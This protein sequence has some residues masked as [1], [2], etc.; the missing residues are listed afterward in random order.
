MAF[1]NDWSNISECN[2]TFSVADVGYRAQVIIALAFFEFLSAFLCASFLVV[3]TIRVK[4][5]LWDTAAKRFS[6]ALT[7]CSILCFLNEGALLIVYLDLT[8]QLSNKWYIWYHVMRIYLY[9]AY[10]LY[11]TAS[12]VWLLLQTGGPV[13]PTRL[14]NLLSSR[15]LVIMEAVIQ[16]S[17]PLLSLTNDIPL[18][19]DYG[20]YSHQVQ[21]DKG[22]GLLPTLSFLILCILLSCCVLI[23]CFT[24]LILGFFLIRFL[25]STFTTRRI[26]ILILKLNFLCITT[27]SLIAHDFVLYTS[28][29]SPFQ[30]PYMLGLNVVFILFF[31]VSLMLLNYP[32]DTWCLNCFKKSPSRSPLLPINN[33]E[34]EQTN[35]KSVWDHRCVPSHTTTN[36]P[37]EMSDCRTDCEEPVYAAC[38]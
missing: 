21:L 5:R 22:C 13:F 7:I 24:S 8:N 19:I 35:P 34:G 9:T 17:I 23:I 31:L 14:K 29:S 3:L 18:F 15:Q 10:D 25:N 26:K 1:T 20:T 30:P 6:F 33:T 38:R 11:L 32:L 16:V 2:H 37:P 4:K 36:Y 12:L 27:I 28:H